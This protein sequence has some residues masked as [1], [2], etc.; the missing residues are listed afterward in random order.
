MRYMVQVLLLIVVHLAYGADYV[1][2]KKR[3]DEITPGIVMGDLVY[4]EGRAGHMFLTIYTAAP[5]AQA[6]LVMVHGIGVQT[7]FL[8]TSRPN[9]SGM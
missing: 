6:G 7:I 3:A 5:N 1:R 4:L 9:S 8:T 2:E